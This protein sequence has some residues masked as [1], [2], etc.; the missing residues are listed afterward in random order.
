MCTVGFRGWVDFDSRDSDTLKV[1]RPF[2][3][4]GDVCGGYLEVEET[5]ELTT[6]RIKVR[7]TGTLPETIPISYGQEVYPVRV[8]FQSTPVPASFRRNDDQLKLRK[9][10]DTLMYSSIKAASSSAGV[11]TVVPSSETGGGTVPTMG[12]GVAQRT[13]KPSTEDGTSGFAPR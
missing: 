10:K 13:E 5:R 4:L 6:V 7:L 11:S 1:G 3:I 9:G 8:E 12:E 2:P